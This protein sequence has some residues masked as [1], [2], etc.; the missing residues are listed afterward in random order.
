MLKMV[1]TFSGIGAQA[2]ALKNAKIDHEILNTADWDINAILAYDYIHNGD[3]V[4]P[5][6]YSKM[7]KEELLKI[8]SKYTLSF[9]GKKPAKE[10]QLERQNIEFLRRLCFSIDRSHNLIS[11]TDIKGE[12]LPNDMN[13]LTYSFPCQDLSLAGCWHG[14]NGGIDRNANNRSSM[15]WQIERMLLERKNQNL[16][17]PRFLLMENVRN[18]MSKKH[19]A[20]FEMWKKSLR[21]MGYVNYVFSLNAIYFGIPQ[22][23]IRAYMVSVY[24]GN[25][26]KLK[27]KVNEY[28]E[29]NNLEKVTD[30]KQLNRKDLHIKDILRLDYTN[31]VYKKEAE[32]SQPKDTS[33]R[34]DIYRDNEKLFTSGKYAKIA[35][36]LTTKQ[37]RHPNSGV[38]D[39]YNEKNGMS[40]FRYI[41]PREGFMFMGFDESDYEALLKNNFLVSARGNVFTRDKMNKMAGN[42]IVVNVLEEIFKQIDYIDKKIFN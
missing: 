38:I 31:P 13:I 27:K 14:N 2:K 33:S 36:T 35:P 40:N 22:K 41:T 28:F 18:I 24:V 10:G 20:N 30:P 34:R 1:E 3:Y 6:K 15:L 7:N 25:N 42:S 9:D 21:E 26:E 19:E 11:V 4:E 17:M 5:N 16:P 37:D 23:R 8:L 29:K 12:D 32:E 39:F